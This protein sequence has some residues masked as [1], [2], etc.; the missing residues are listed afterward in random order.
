M[1]LN[2]RYALVS[3]D[4]KLLKEMMDNIAVKEILNACPRLTIK[5]NTLFFSG[6]DK[7]NDYDLLGTVPDITEVTFYINQS[8]TYIDIMW[9]WDEL[10]VLDFTQLSSE[11]GFYPDVDKDEIESYCKKHKLD[12]YIGFGDLVTDSPF[13]TPKG[14]IAAVLYLSNKKSLGYHKLK[15]L[16][17]IENVGLF[18]IFLCYLQS[19]IGEFHI[20][21]GLTQRLS[22]DIDVNFKEEEAHLLILNHTNLEDDCDYGYLQNVAQEPDFL[23]N[24]EI[25]C[26]CLP[27][28]ASDKLMDL[29]LKQVAIVNDM[30]V[31]TFLHYDMIHTIPGFEMYTHIAGDIKTLMNELSKKII[32]KLNDLYSHS[33]KGERSTVNFINL[34]MLPTTFNYMKNAIMTEL[35]SLP[36]TEVIEVLTGKINK[37]IVKWFNGNLLYHHIVNDLYP[38]PKLLY[39]SLLNDITTYKHLPSIHLKYLKKIQAFYE[40]FIIDDDVYDAYKDFIV[41]K[42]IYNQLIE[43]LKVNDIYDYLVAFAKHY[44]LNTDLVVRYMELISLAPV[45]EAYTDVNE[46]EE[47]LTKLK[48]NLLI[49]KF[50]NLLTAQLELPNNEKVDKFLLPAIDH[51]ISSNMNQLKDTLS[52]RDFKWYDFYHTSSI[53]QLLWNEFVNYY[54]HEKMLETIYAFL[55]VTL[56]KDKILK[57]VAKKNLLSL[58]IN[59]LKSNLSITELKNA[60][61]V[62][63]SH[64]KRPVEEPKK[65]PKGKKV[66]TD[67]KIKGVKKSKKVEEEKVEEKVEEDEE[68]QSI[69]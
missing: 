23:P 61:Y 58:Y 21:D 30:D 60:V 54:T 36:L 39:T 69:D 9:N 29:L 34:E 31:F 12:G 8:T 26:P 41:G 47:G 14:G 53:G 56:Y 40:P 10:E 62:H 27:I 49:L 68:T 2:P 19:I 38:K 66:K 57:L 15:Y 37:K 5:S 6:N 20:I 63:L 48:M 45:A 18:N 50:K 64:A 25:V 43:L 46:Y 65:S 52:S 7:V 67:V 35:Q 55:G 4:I 59:Y 3:Y 44:D 28:G 32:Y 11:L 1:N 33:P 13:Y 24:Q 16:G 17:F 51:I 42:I 22:I